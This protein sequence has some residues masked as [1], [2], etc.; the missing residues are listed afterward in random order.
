MFPEKRWYLYDN[1]S[2]STVLKH[3]YRSGSKVHCPHC[4]SLLK[5]RDYSASCCE[6]VFKTG[7]GEIHQQR[8]LETHHH[9]RGRGWQSLRPYD[10]PP[11]LPP[12]QD[13]FS[14]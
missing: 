13:L 12:S 8:P 7:H 6:E 14:V 4:G 3:P 1:V 11:S 9:I 10:K 5:V 2:G